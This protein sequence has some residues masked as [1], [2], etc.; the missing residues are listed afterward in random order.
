MDRHVALPRRSEDTSC[1]A[2]VQQRT[3][4]PRLGVVRSPSD[5]SDVHHESGAPPRVKRVT[6]DASVG[7]SRVPGQSRADAGASHYGLGAFRPTAG[8]VRRLQFQP[9]MSPGL[10]RSKTTRLNWIAAVKQRALDDRVR[11]R[12][13]RAGR[14]PAPSCRRPHRCLAAISAPHSTGLRLARQT[15]TGTRRAELR[16]CSRERWA[17]SGSTVGTRLGSIRSRTHR[18]LGTAIGRIVCTAH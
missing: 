14:G 8:H 3:N 16:R 7:T 9:W 17:A 5:G 18:I 4:R 1:A 2:T 13:R 11:A 10:P 6:G 15:P 12:L